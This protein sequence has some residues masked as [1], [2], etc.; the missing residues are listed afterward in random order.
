MTFDDDVAAAVARI[1][2][3]RG[4]ALSEAVNDL[5]RAGLHNKQTRRRFRQ[6]SRVVGLR[7]DPT[8]VGEALEVLDRTD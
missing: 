1:R 8:N 5:I 2:Q 6:R 7:I 3:E 4:L